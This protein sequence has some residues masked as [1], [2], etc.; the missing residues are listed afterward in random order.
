MLLNEDPYTTNRNPKLQAAMIRDMLVGFLREVTKEELSANNEELLSVNAVLNSLAKISQDYELEE[1]NEFDMDNDGST[2]TFYTL[3]DDEDGISFRP[4]IDADIIDSGT[5]LSFNEDGTNVVNEIDE[6]KMLT[7]NDVLVGL[8]LPQLREFSLGKLWDQ[9][10]STND[11]IS[12][13]LN[14][15]KDEGMSIAQGTS[16]SGLKMTSFAVKA[17]K[18]S[19]KQTDLHIIF[20]EATGKS[21]IVGDKPTLSLSENFNACAMT[22]I[23]RKDP[24]A[25]ANLSRALKGLLSNQDDAKKAERDLCSAFIVRNV[26]PSVEVK[27]EHSLS[28]LMLAKDAM[29]ILPQYILKR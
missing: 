8:T 23:D 17:E 7:Q 24:S 1:S 4:F 9:S 26:A 15:V 27:E 5:F 29:N 10:L 19:D 13:D 28:E 2:R 18:N 12:D 25:Q 21:I 22:F 16:K 14:G 3:N 11:L 6:S 20:N